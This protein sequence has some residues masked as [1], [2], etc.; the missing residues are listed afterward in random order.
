MTAHPLTD[1]ACLPDIEDVAFPVQE[2]INP[3]PDG[4]SQNTV[5]DEV[6]NRSH[7]VLLAGEYFLE[8]LN[9]FHFEEIS[10]THVEQNTGN[11]PYG[12]TQ[13]L[14]AYGRYP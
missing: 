3:C 12:Q 6:R 14:R 8:G 5:F 9:F 2:K 1:R 11:N 13:R 10:K 7:E 4:Q